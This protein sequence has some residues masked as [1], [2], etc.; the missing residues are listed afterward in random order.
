MTKGE[1]IMEQRIEDFLLYLKDVKKKSDNT[2]LSYKR[3]LLSFTNFIENGNVKDFSKVTST[4]INSYILFLEKQGKSSAT[5]ARNVSSINTFFRY[6]IVIGEVK[7]DPT[8]RVKAPK[9]DKKLPNI[10]TTEEVERLLTQPNT[11]SLKGIRDKA[12][13]E[14]LYATGIRVSELINMKKSDVNL[15]LGYIVCR[16]E[17]KDRVIPFGNKVKVALS[18]YIYEVKELE[19]QEEWLFLNRFGRKMS[20][21]GVW[22]IIKGYADKA[23]IKKEITP[24]TLRHSVGAHLLKSGKDIKE[25][26]E[27]M[28]HIDIASTSIYSTM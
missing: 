24:H 21:Q 15:Q 20:R 5:V 13:L 22:K 28:G 6:L 8:E 27:I 17:K 10:L 12:L 3:D 11:K 14:L 23:E 2:I 4:N 25:V 1:K 16:N 26:Q 18:K 7:G 19:E 9:I